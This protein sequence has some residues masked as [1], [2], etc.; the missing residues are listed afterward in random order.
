MAANKKKRNRKRKNKESKLTDEQ[1][2]SM[3]TDDLCNY[4]ENKA[5]QNEGGSQNRSGSRSSGLKG[6]PGALPGIAKRRMG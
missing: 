3:A 4:I 5:S 2:H 1:I 6:L